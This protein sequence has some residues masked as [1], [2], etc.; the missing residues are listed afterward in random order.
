LQALDL[1]HLND[2]LCQKECIEVGTS[3]TP[4]HILQVYVQHLRIQHPL[5]DQQEHIQFH[6]SIPIPLLI[7]MLFLDFEEQQDIHT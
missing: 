2:N 3:S 6:E 5:E 1:L 4:I 7:S